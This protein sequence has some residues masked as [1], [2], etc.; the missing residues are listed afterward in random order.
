MTSNK[1]YD[2]YGFPVTHLTQWD[3]NVILKIHNYKCDVAP[4]VHFSTEQ[5]ESSKT[6]RSTLEDSVVSVVVPNSLLIEKGVLDVCVFQ[7]DEA[8]DD[9]HVV[10]RYRL[11]I[12]SKPKPDDYEYVDNTEVIELS[13]LSVRL[14]ALIAEA[15]G[16]VDEKIGELEAAYDST[17]QSIRDDIADDVANLNQS[18]SD[19]RDKLE[20]DID[21]TLQT[22]LESVSDG[23]PRGIFTDVAQLADS[24]SGIYLYINPQSDDNGYVFW[25]D[26]E[27][28]TKLLHYMGMVIND[29]TITYEML[30]NS[31]KGYVCETVLSYIL[32]ADGW[33]GLAQEIDVSDEYSVT[34][35]TKA[36]IDIGAATYDQL[37]QDG[38]GGI[39][40]Q[41]NENNDNKLIAHSIGNVPTE[42]VAIQLTLREVK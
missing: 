22:M 33:N 28:T 12:M 31:L 1:C 6:V 16:A 17:V 2:Q 39:Y 40:I 5:S 36:N 24:P 18:I 20:T 26:G 4:I 21:N 42:D 41:T 35:H 14:E 32:T 10:R 25:W 3:S 8:T 9:G 27:T 38:C 29:N 37:V 30:A 11:P 34:S 15:E 19:N 7:Y 13:S 23:S